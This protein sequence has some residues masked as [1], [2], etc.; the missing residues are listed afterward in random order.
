M[1]TRPTCAAIVVVAF[2]LVEGVRPVHA[3][4]LF[5]HWGGILTPKAKEWQS[6]S[7]EVALHSEFNRCGDIDSKDEKLFEIAP[8][9]MKG[10]HGECRDKEFLALFDDTTQRITREI[11]KKVMSLAVDSLYRIGSLDKTLGYNLLRYDRQDRVG[12]ES[13]EFENLYWHQTLQTGWRG[14]EITEFLQNDFAHKGIQGLGGEPLSDV[15][16]QGT[17]DGF[18]FQFAT[19]HILFLP[20]LRRQPAGV[21]EIGVSPFYLSVQA[22]AGTEFWGGSGSIGVSDFPIELWI[23]D[24][25]WIRWANRGYFQLKTFGVYRVGVQNNFGLFG[26]SP[27]D[28][29]QLSDTWSLFQAGLRLETHLWSFLN[30][31]PL[32]VSAAW[33]QHSGLFTKR[34]VDSYEKEGLRTLLGT[35]IIEVPHFQFVLVNDNPNET[36]GGASFAAALRY[37]FEVLK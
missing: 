15:P 37:P 9:M 2:L 21:S 17:Y 30:F 35:L 5:D 33:T 25:D 20:V 23:G 1:R 32:A 16:R 11:D 26:G 19:E 34:R 28:S 31:M 7:I 27:F 36:D 29:S 22:T 4:A 24:R 10:R 8:E 13:V 12:G 3:Q 6:V 14:D 18:V